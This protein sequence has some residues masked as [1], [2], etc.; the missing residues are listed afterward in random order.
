MQRI[1]YED[2]NTRQQGSYNRLFVLLVA[3]ILL[4]CDRPRVTSNTVEE[5]LCGHW[6]SSDPKKHELLLGRVDST[7][8]VGSYK[9]VYERDIDT[10]FY[11]IMRSG[12]TSDLGGTDYLTMFV[13]CGNGRVTVERTLSFLILSGAKTLINVDDIHLVDGNHLNWDETRQLNTLT[14][15]GETTLFPPS[16]NTTASAPA[17]QFTSVADAQREA[18]RLYPS[19]GV[20]GSPFNRAFLAR[21][22]Q[23]QQQRPKYFNDPGWPVALAREIAATSGS[24]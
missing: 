3:L 24:Q 20:A 8:G 9:A 6:R 21:H 12:S 1:R 7:S 15:V 14:F 23:Y 19:L 5:R 10:G 4:G 18:M 22:K 17:A 13:T 2:L 16:L 11:R